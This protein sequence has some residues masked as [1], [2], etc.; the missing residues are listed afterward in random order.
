VS[1]CE[2]GETHYREFAMHSSTSPF[3][4]Y[5]EYRAEN[6]IRVYQNLKI[7]EFSNQFGCFVMGSSQRDFDK[8]D[9]QRFLKKD[10]PPKT[11]I[12]SDD[13]YHYNATGTGRRFD[14]E[15]IYWEFITQ[16]ETKFVRIER[17]DEDDFTCCIGKF[18]SQYSFDVL[19]NGGRG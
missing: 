18:E 8:G 1:G 17:W 13:T 11:F 5:L 7:A 12:G 4:K 9:I 6:H 3:P 10:K 16:D 15:F 14:S 19:G 2:I